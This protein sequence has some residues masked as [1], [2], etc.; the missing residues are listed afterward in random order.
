[1]LPG[2]GDGVP[3]TPAAAESCFGT[4]LAV[5]ELAPPLSC[6]SVVQPTAGYATHPPWLAPLL[7]GNVTGVVPGLSVSSDEL[8][9]RRGGVLLRLDI[10]LFTLSRVAFRMARRCGCGL[11]TD[12]CLLMCS[13]LGRSSPWGPAF[14]MQH[15]RNRIS[16]V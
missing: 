15:P 6:P 12:C 13:G 8:S 1:M 16:S 4:Q 9:P 14:W 3:S 7:F 11:D 10:R 5:D 2:D